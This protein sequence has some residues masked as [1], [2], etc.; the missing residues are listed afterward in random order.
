VNTVADVF[1]NRAAWA[2][3][4]SDA[5]AFLDAL[6]NDSVDLLV[7]SPPYENARTYSLADELPSGQA[8]ADWMVRVVRAAAPTMSS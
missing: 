4:Q 5:I 7:T 2:C 1:E 8:W 3:V 6:P